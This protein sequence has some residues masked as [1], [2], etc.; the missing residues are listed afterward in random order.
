MVPIDASIVAFESNTWNL[1]AYCM[2]IRE[3]ELGYPIEPF[4]SHAR[5]AGGADDL[6]IPPGGPRPRN[7]V[8]PVRP[9]EAVRQN[10]DG[11][12]TIVPRDVPPD[13]EPKN[14]NKKK[15]D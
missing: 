4:R 5:L 7:Q 1:A 13:Q 14:K 10:E 2:Q 3:T 9:G 11:T 15:E 8:Y 12:Y 6:V